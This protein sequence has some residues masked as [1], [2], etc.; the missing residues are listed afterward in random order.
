M[1]VCQRCHRLRLH[2][3]VTVENTPTLD[4]Y[5]CCSLY[6]YGK[7]TSRADLLGSIIILDTQTMLITN[8]CH[9]RHRARPTIEAPHIYLHMFVEQ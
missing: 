2:G 5:F 3:F 7:L 9:C 6:F 8:K 4:V 1:S